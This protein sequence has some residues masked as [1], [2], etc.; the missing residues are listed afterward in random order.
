MKFKDRIKRALQANRQIQYKS[1]GFIKPDGG[2]DQVVYGARHSQGGVNRTSEIELEGGG[3]SPDGT[4]KAGEVITTIYDDGGTPQEFYMSHKNG[5]AQKYLQAKAA[6][7]GSLSQQTKQEFAKL[8]ESM[9]PNGSPTDIAANGGYKTKKYPVGGFPAVAGPYLP[10]GPINYLPSPT[11][12]NLPMSGRG[13]PGSP[14]G[15][16]SGIPQRWTPPNTPPNTAAKPNFTIPSWMKKT[17]GLTAAMLDTEGFE[18]GAI[19]NPEGEVMKQSDLFNESDFVGGDARGGQIVTNYF[20]GR[21]Q[22]QDVRGNITGTQGKWF[23]EDEYEASKA[24]EAKETVVDN[25]VDEKIITEPEVVVE[26]N[27]TPGPKKSSSDPEVKATQEELLEQGYKLPKYGADGY[28]GDETQGAIDARNSDREWR[29]GPDQYDVGA[30][31]LEWDE[32]TQDWIPKQGAKNRTD[33][34]SWGEQGWNND[35]DEVYYDPD[36]NPI[37]REE[38]TKIDEEV[39]TDEE[40]KG[41]NK[42]F[43]DRIGMN[44]ITDAI[45]YAS[46]MKANKQAQKANKKIGELRVDSKKVQPQAYNPELVDLGSEKKTVRE[47]TSATVQAAMAQGKSISEIRAIASGGAESVEKIGKTESEL[48]KKQNNFAKKMNID[49]QYKADV[50]NMSNDRLDQIANNDNLADMYKNSIAITQN[51]R[52][53]ISTKIKDDKLR[54]SMDN[55]MTMFSKAVSGGTGLDDRKFQSFIDMMSGSNLFSQEDIQTMINTNT[56]LNNLDGKKEKE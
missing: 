9:N 36:G 33:G 43:L 25:N 6:N 56:E 28:M 22:R 16:G 41:R 3:Y 15:S 54:R 30:D 42:N 14:F 45:E 11:G 18:A 19:R 32:E 46:I 2:G 1:G 52:N 27:N 40:Q 10:S 21:V 17:V 12:T 26:T 13:I 31:N 38:F 39:G 29:G 50:L 8:N 49:N 51:M 5:I 48:Q 20:N 35:G 53:A 4:P 55:Q 7:G 24:E 23:Y 44:N 47:Q 34:D 37:T